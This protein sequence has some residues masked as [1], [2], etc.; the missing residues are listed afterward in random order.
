MFTDSEEKILEP[1]ARV[2]WNDI[3]I[4][5]K[6]DEED[7]SIIGYR[8]CYIYGKHPLNTRRFFYLINHVWKS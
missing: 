8:N 1:T 5:D 6:P 2:C 4:P 7:S 3:S